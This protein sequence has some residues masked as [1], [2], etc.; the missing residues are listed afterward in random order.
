TTRVSAERQYG[1]NDVDAVDDRRA[2]PGVGPYLGPAP[3]GIVG[4]D[5]DRG[6]LLTLGEG[7]EEELRNAAVELHVAELVDAQ[8]VDSAVTGVGLREGH[9]VGCFAECVV[10]LGC[11]GVFDEVA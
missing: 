9:L 1:T 10:A 6:L 3:E 2:Q 5:R 11:R 8:Q 7:L 4:R